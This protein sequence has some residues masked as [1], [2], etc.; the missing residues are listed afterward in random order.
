MHNLLKKLLASVL[1]ISTYQASAADYAA[2]SRG[3]GIPE[4]ALKTYCKKI[5]CRYDK[6]KDKVEVVASD[7]S[8]LGAIAGSETRTLEFAW[9]SGAS[10]ILVNVYDVINLYKDSWDFV[11]AAEIYVG[12]EMLFK[13]T[14]SVDRRVGS[15]NDI[16][17]KAEKV[18]VI[19]GEL[20][21]DIAERIAAANPKE[22]TIRFYGKNGYV[23]KEGIRAHKLQN[24][25]ML[26]KA[27]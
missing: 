15:Y 9:A 7:G 1:V 13:V 11:E 4:S 18:E 25:I 2:M 21:I 5:V 16:A 17:K 12:K 23:D 10:T 6:L 22:V 19:S 20:P 27:K 26:A 24:V 8:V 14:G 3:S